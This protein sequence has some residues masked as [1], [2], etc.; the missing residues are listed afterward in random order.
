MTAVKKADLLGTRLHDCRH[1]FASSCMSSGI[2]L[3]TVGRLLG[4]NDHLST[5][6]YSHLANDTL[7][8]AVEAGAAKQNVAWTT[9][10]RI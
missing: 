6:R 2:D 5:M 3:F 10:D 4:H 9:P 7:L 8:A 1:S